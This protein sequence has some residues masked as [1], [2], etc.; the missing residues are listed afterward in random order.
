[1]C[2]HEWIFLKFEMWI[3]GSLPTCHN[4]FLGHIF[5]GV[6]APFR[7]WCNWSTQLL[8]HS[9]DH[10]DILLDFIS[11]AI[12]WTTDTMLGAGTVYRYFRYYR[13]SCIFCLQKTCNVS[14]AWEQYSENYCFVQNTYFLPLDEHIPKSYKERD[15]RE[16]GY[17]QW[18]PFVL[19]LQA[20]LFYL[21]CL[22][23]RLLNWQ[24]GE[25][26]NSCLVS[27]EVN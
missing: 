11:K 23:W 2:A 1:M 4:V 22:F 12:C 15:E 14:G 24:S 8:L 10:C 26:S 16:I 7:W 27:V 9:Y 3:L 18:V 5:K 19:A 21:P 20:V 6:E 17:Y 25:C 13:I